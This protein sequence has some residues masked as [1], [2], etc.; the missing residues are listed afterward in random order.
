V[1]LA[2]EVNGQP[3]P[4]QHGFPLRLVVP[5][6]YGMTNVK[7]LGR[8]TAVAEPFAG[9]QQA[10][11][12][13]FLREPD[14]AGEPVNRMAPRALMVPPGIPDFM[15]RRRF[16]SRAP[17]AI[18]GRAWSGVA[19][20][21]RVQLSADHGLTWHDAHLD[22]ADLGPYA[23]RSWSWTWE[24]A[25]QGDYELWCRAQDAAG[26]EQPVSENWNV[27]GYA[28]N[29]VQRVLVTIG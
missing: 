6:W 5:G 13:R 7:W 16:V 29:A 3:L 23:W 10:E 20:V 21:T 9:F 17:C 26:N 25:E 8:V 24:P 14:D 18:R 4:P 28:N 15:T 12:Y 22:D 2:Y 19:P 11:G 1:I 27:K